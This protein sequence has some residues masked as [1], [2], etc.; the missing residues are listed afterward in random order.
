MVIKLL[1]ILPAR[2]SLVNDSGIE[3]TVD[4]LVR[5]KV[6]LSIAKGSGVIIA[7]FIVL[8]ALAQC[9]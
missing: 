3:N 6:A 1:L 5:F 9:T 7:H 2:G 8:I 4:F